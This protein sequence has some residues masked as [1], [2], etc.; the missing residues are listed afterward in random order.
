MQNS[1]AKHI[2]SR[3][4]AIRLAETMTKFEYAATLAE[5]HNWAS[6]SMNNYGGKQYDALYNFYMFA[7]NKCDSAR[8]DGV[9]YYN[10]ETFTYS[11][12]PPEGVLHKVLRGMR[13]PIT[14]E[15][16]FK[17]IKDG[18]NITLTMGDN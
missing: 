3:I 18:H 15:Q 5:A 12:R 8:K 13:C 17:N 9:L 1:I 14:K 4:Y 7:G 16:A 2:L 11:C 10:A 6:K